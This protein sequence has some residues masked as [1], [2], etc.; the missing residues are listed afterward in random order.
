MENK[1]DNKIKMT[2]FNKIIDSLNLEE[3][4]VF[5]DAYHQKYGYNRF[6]YDLMNHKF[7]FE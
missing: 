7:Y 4:K 3:N 6:F 2:G 5:F 1:K